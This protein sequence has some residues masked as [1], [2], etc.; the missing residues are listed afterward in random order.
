[1]WQK[2]LFAS[3]CWR[4]RPRRRAGKEFRD[5][6]NERM[7]K[8]L[9]TSALRHPSTSSVPPPRACAQ[10]FS[11]PHSGAHL[12]VRDVELLKVADEALRQRVT[13]IRVLILCT[14][15]ASM[16]SSTNRDRPPAVSARE[17]CMANPE[18]RRRV[19]AV[20]TVDKMSKT[21]R[22]TPIPGP[23]TEEMIS[24]NC[25]TAVL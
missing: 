20:E 4:Q 11:V 3:I 13:C 21:P 22:R 6:N 8:S 10:S 9:N 18:V 2:R 24:G 19:L 23:S 1:M 16:V 14:Q 17:L 12:F 7:A 15:R 25:N 5:M